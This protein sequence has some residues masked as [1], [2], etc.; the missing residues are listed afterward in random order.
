MQKF[1]DAR[2]VSAS[3]SFSSLICKIGIQQRLALHLPKKQ[4]V[5][6]REGCTEEAVRNTKDTTLTAWFK[7]NNNS[8]IMA[9]TIKVIKTIITT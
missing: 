3:E 2:Y 5:I 6:Y 7:E 4:S 8:T 1:V 9:M